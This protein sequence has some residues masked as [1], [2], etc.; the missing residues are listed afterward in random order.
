MLTVN[1]ILSE[2]RKKTSIYFIKVQYT[3]SG[4]ISAFYSEKADMK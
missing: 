3:L 4:T 1:K 2:A